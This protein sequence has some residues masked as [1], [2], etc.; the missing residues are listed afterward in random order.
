[1]KAKRRLGALLAAWLVFVMAQAHAAGFSPI[2][3][4]RSQSQTKIPGQGAVS[5]TGPKGQ[6]ASVIAANSGVPQGP[7]TPQGVKVAGAQAAA[8]KEPAR[9][10]G[11]AETALPASQKV[12]A[13]QLDFSFIAEA[14]ENGKDQGSQAVEE[15]LRGAFDNGR[16]ASASA[17]ADSVQGAPSRQMGRLEPASD[18]ALQKAADAIENLSSALAAGAPLEAPAA[19]GSPEMNRLDLAVKDLSLAIRARL[20]SSAAALKKKSDLI[21]GMTHDLNN[22]LATIIGYLGYV[23]DAEENQPAPNQDK[24]RIYATMR[25]SANFM[26]EV[27][28]YTQ[29]LGKV[30]GGRLQAELDNVSVAAALR[31]IAALH[32]DGAKEKKITI[33]VEVPESG[34]WVRTD[35]KALRTVL[36]N[37]V[38]NAVKY[39][40]AEGLIIV[41]AG[42][43]PHRPGHAVIFVEDTGIGISV[44]DQEKI[45]AGFHR[46]D[47]GKK[48]ASGSGI[49]LARAKMFVEE[50]LGS[51]LKVQ[52]EP[53][54]GSRFYFDLPLVVPSAQPPKA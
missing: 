35:H 16:G 47:E 53:G 32:E 46:T 3:G 33:A 52:S 23:T 21:G 14:R 39:T 49:G 26:G 42:P 36:N 11:Q 54:K 13:V 12:E 38:G 34:L 37:L 20:E 24:L 22:M 17:E 45:F 18:H 5:S 27:I 50:V 48:M 43:D 28:S 44:E 29:E 9:P 4:G 2:R 25:R 6:P 1:M 40:P 41:G 8:A 7:T 51:S 15:G 19:Q 10:A 31:D 30:E